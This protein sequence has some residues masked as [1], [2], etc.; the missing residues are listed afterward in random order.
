MTGISLADVE[1][2]IVKATENGFKEI[3]LPLIFCL[4]TI[5]FLVSYV[6]KIKKENRKS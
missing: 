2:S 4:L 6:D 1:W 5:N 3:L